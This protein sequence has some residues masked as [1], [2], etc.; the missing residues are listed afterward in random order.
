MDTATTPMSEAAT[1]DWLRARL[2][3][4]LGLEVEDIDLER[5]ITDYAIDSRQALVLV[6]DVEDLLGRKLAATL[7]WDHPTLAAMA[8]YIARELAGA[9]PARRPADRTWQQR[10][11]I[12]PPL[13]R[14]TEPEGERLPAGLPPVID[15]HVHLFPEPILRALWRWFE[16]HAWEIRYKL[17][18]EQICEF[19]FARGVSRIVA[20]QYAHRPGLAE[21]MNAFMQSLC[22]AEP[23]IIGLAT[24]F[25]GEP[26]ARRILRDG[27]AAGLRGVKLHCHVQGVGPDAAAMHEIYE[28]CVRADRPLVMHAGREPVS[29][30][31]ACDPYAICDA[32]HIDRV[33]RSYPRLRL[34]IPHMGADQYDDYERLVCRHD[35]LWLDSSCAVS[36]FPETINRR[37]LLV[38]PD[39]VLYGTDFPT[40]PAAWDR[41]L[42]HLITY[43][44]GPDAQ[45][46]ILG[47]NAA[48]L[49]GAPVDIAS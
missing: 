11:L 7:T 1:R 9:A 2:A 15:A 10:G 31:Y 46:R 39:R 23:R 44:L 12:Q 35:N 47:R 8:A 30:A 29:T 24:V 21:R 25:P 28:E 42:R 48:E 36:A 27:F 26:D 5:P 32:E 16:Q 38:R 18:S 13:P 45:E 40:M 4:L 6:G 22:A 14:S 43:E 20:L 17:L 19:L 49:Y 37:A 41:E 33:L 3:D 34:C